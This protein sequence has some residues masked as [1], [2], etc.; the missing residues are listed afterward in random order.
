MN[1][2]T[3]KRTNSITRVSAL[4]VAFTACNLGGEVDLGPGRESLADVAGAGGEDS[5]DDGTAGEISAVGGSAGTAGST[6]SGGT[7]GVTAAQGG[8][9]W[10][11]NMP[12]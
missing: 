11:D 9:C 2:K 8:P 12:D 5:G 4:A 10:V 3:S 7:A 6:T 1:T